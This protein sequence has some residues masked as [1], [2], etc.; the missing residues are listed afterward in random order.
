VEG[1]HGV[2]QEEVF[3]VFAEN[4]ARMRELLLAAVGSLPAERDCACPHA[5]DGIKLPITLP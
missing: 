5:L 2:T 1:D 4:T 3:R